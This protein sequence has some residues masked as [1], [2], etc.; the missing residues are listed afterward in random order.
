M[1]QSSDYEKSQHERRC[2]RMDLLPASRARNGVG[3]RFNVDLYTIDNFGQNPELAEDMQ[4]S[5]TEERRAI[6]D[7]CV[8]WKVAGVKGMKGSGQVIPTIGEVK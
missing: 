3:L 1:A 7:A 6:F 2:E 5:F 8:G 4:V